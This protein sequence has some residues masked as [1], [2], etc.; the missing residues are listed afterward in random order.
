MRQ[1]NSISRRTILGA[2]GAGVLAAAC[3]DEPSAQRPDAG[4]N[5]RDGGADTTAEVNLLNALIAAEGQ[6]ID[7]YT[8]GAAV[9]AGATAAD[10]L[11]ALKDALGAIAGHFQQ[12]HRDHGVLLANAVRALGATPA[13]IEAQTFTLPAGFQPKI[14]N[15]LS[16]A[17]NAEKAATIAYNGAVET[18]KMSPHRFVAATIQGDESQHYVVLYSILRGLV[19][20]GP[21][22]NVQTATDVVPAAFVAAVTGV[23]SATSLADVPDFDLT[24]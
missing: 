3:S 22:L 18:L 23:P 4:S 20:P 15:V 1:P 7:A 24:R 6:A 9:I 13:D 8:Q 16:L 5:D 10:P 11:F 2:A 19:N 12:Q 14:V 17:A 21:A